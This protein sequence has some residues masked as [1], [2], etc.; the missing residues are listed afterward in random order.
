MDQSASVFALRDS[1]L[2]VSFKPTLKADVVSFPKTDPEFSFVVA[3]SFVTS[4]KQ[5]TGPIHY[6]LRV[7]E[8]TLAAQVLAKIFRLKKALPKDESPLGSSLRGFHDAY[9]EQEEGISDNTQASPKTFQEQLK[10]LIQMTEDYLPQEEG[11]TREQISSL[12]G[13]TVDELNEQYTTKVPVRAEHFKLRQR[14][15]HVFSE[16]L[17]VQHFM[18]L[19]NSKD[20]DPKQLAGKLGQLLNGTQDSCRDAY[21]CSCP[22]IDELCEIARG[23]GAYGSRLTGAGWGGCCVHLVPSDKVEAVK[24]AWR[25]KYYAKRFPKLSEEELEEAIVVSKPGRGSLTWDVSGKSNV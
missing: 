22:E 10:K 1:A 12:L 17:R 25:T 21:E 18:Q 24:N 19:L 15:L 6:N 14:A 8:C 4:N 13:I 3:Q 16:A 7:V 5:V 9:F 20:E 23:A 11:Y 2:L